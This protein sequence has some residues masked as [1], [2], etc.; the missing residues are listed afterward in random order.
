MRYQKVTITL[1]EDIMEKINMVMQANA[2]DRSAAISMMLQRAPL[3][4]LLPPDD[5]AKL[6]ERLAKLAS[7][8]K[9]ENP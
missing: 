1:R 7:D 4:T 8:D 3:A 9:N 6:E 2:I 5:L